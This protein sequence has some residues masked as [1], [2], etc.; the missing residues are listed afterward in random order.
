MWSLDL[1]PLCLCACVWL[2]VL[3]M[4]CVLCLLCLCVVCVLTLS[5]LVQLVGTRIH[6]RSA[7]VRACVC[8]VVLCVC[9]SVLL[10]LRLCLCEGGL[11]L[12]SLV[13]WASCVHVFCLCVLMC[14]SMYVMALLLQRDGC[15]E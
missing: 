8:N 2:C 7:C 14:M 11:E 1:V 5:W 4:Q 3:C 12:L 6:M 9:V 13:C 15:G 10:S